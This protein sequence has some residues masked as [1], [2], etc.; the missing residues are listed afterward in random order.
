MQFAL[1]GSQRGRTVRAFATGFATVLLAVAAASG[2]ANAGAYINQVNV[3]SVV[4]HNFHLGNYTGNRGNN[5]PQYQVPTNNFKLAPEFM[6]PPHGTNLAQTLQIGA[7]NNILQFQNGHGNVSIAG[8]IG[9]HEKL[10]V[11]QDGNQLFS[12]VWLLGKGLKAW[13]IQ[14][15]GAAPVNMLIARLPNGSLLIKH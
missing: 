14:P 15:P 7:Y 6:V 13:V 11:V 9:S 1:S 10:G 4:P 12:N 2:P 5:M 3:G 8:T